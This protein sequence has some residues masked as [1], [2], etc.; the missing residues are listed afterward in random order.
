MSESLSSTLPFWGF[1]R[2][3]RISTNVV[4]PDPDG[5]TRPINSPFFIFKFISLSAAT[6]DPGYEYD[7][8]LIQMVWLN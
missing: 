1:N 8:F 7:K 6:S 4:F 2:P 5:P 3:K